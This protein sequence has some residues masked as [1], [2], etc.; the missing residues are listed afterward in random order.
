MGRYPLRTTIGEYM[1]S[2]K[3]FLAETTYIERDRKLRAFTRL[4]EKL[5]DKDPALEQD[6]ARWTEREISAILLDMRRR[7]LSLGTQKKQLGHI[8]AVLKFVGNAVMPRMKARN[9]HM[10][11]RG[12]YLAQEAQPVQRSSYQ[13][14]S[15]PRN[16]GCCFTRSS[17]Y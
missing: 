17:G 2:S 7:G 12:Q 16:R 11:P 15:S 1:T 5:C 9:P 3:D 10:M 4:Y 14:N 8:N 13:T 6:P